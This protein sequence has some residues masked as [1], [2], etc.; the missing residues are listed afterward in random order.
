MSAAGAATK[1]ADVTGALTTTTRDD[2]TTQ[3]A[4]NGKPLYR[5]GADSAAGDTK[6]NGAGN[7]NWSVATPSASVAAATPPATSASGT[8]ATPAGATAPRISTISN[9]KIESFTVKAG[10]TVQWNNAD[11]DDVPHALIGDKGEFD[12]KG[13]I[14]VSG[15]RFTFD[16][17]GVIAYSCTIHPTMTGAITVQ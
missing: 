1:S 16:K 2:G 13:P 5:Y 17:P 14:P 15:F 9:L 11:G 6:G 4:Y 3:I 8:A 7:G 10:T 12:S